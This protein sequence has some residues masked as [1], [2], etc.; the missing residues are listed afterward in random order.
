MIRPIATSLPG[1]IRDEKMTVSPSPSLSS[2]V[3]HAIR[4]SAA[5]GSP[6]PPVAMISTSLARQ[7]HRFVEADRR[8]EILEIAGRLRDAQD[9]FERA[10]GDAD[11]AAGFDAR[12]GRSSAAARR[13]RRR[14]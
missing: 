13:W 5:R 9:A 1:M 12:R 11:L 3:P 2:C 10:A 8:R 14:W 7:A 6:C 4:P